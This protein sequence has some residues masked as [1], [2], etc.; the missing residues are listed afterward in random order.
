MENSNFANVQ[1]TH[2]EIPLTVEDKAE[3]AMKLIRLEESI[4]QREVERKAAMDAFKEQISTLAAE[5]S[6]VRQILTQ[7]YVKQEVPVDVLYD[8]PSRGMKTL[9]HTVTGETVRQ[10]PMTHEDRQMSLIGRRTQ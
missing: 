1:T 7:G 9:V 4:E 10:E 8:H 2:R 5:R 6:E 3:Y